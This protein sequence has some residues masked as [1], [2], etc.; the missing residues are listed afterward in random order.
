MNCVFT[1]GRW[2]KTLGTSVPTTGREEKKKGRKHMSS[3]KQKKKGSTAHIRTFPLIGK[4]GGGE[5]TKK[6]GEK[7]G[8]ES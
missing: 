1:R 2:K 4:L 8:G 5:V 6:K 7:E 3:E